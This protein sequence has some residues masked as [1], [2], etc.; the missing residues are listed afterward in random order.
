MES[1]C[2]HKL[3]DP[4]V[5]FR[6]P[7]VDDAYEAWQEFKKG[8]PIR[9][10]AGA[11]HW[12]NIQRET[13]ETTYGFP[14]LP[15]TYF[16]YLTVDA[17]HNPSVQ[18]LDQIGLH[19]QARWRDDSLFRPF[20]T[21]RTWLYESYAFGKTPVGTFKLGKI[22]NR[23]GFDWDESFW[24]NVQYFDGYK[25]DPDWGVSWEQIWALSNKL[26]LD[27]SAQ[28]FLAEDNVNGTFPG[29]D[30][31]SA[32]DYDEDTTFVLRLAPKWSFTDSLSLSAGITGF[33]SE[34]KSEESITGFDDE[35]INGYAFDLNFRIGN[36]SILGEVLQVFGV[37]NPAHYATGG[38]SDES[39]N[40]YIGANYD[41][42]PLLLLGAYS[43]GEYDN[44]GGEQ[45]LYVLETHASLTKYITLILGYAYWT[46]QP[47][48]TRHTELQDGF[49]IAI[50]W[51]L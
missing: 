43:R 30:A 12:W 41:F 24:G 7:C 26:S 8:S 11:Y 4:D 6:L 20:F 10:S 50:L 31:E 38:A 51:S 13:G 29:G 47:A 23:I 27:S 34:I 40:F 5:Y 2:S 39:R 49:Q 36:L 37:R 28:V 19:T 3:A 32:P 45:D 22:R 15:G 21:E 33:R 1:F 25:L 14:T 42:G 18:G 9:V 16:Y 35:V 46:V 17:E 44:P 48:D